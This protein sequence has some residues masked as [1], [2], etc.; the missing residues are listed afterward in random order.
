MPASWL[1]DSSGN[2]ISSKRSIPHSEKDRCRG[3]AG[4]FF[5]YKI[6]GATAMYYLIESFARHLISQIG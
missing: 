2:S 1:C 5:A 3:V 6:A 4:L